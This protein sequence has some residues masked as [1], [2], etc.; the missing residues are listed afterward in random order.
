MFDACPRQPD[1]PDFE[2][3]Q[4]APPPAPCPC[5]G[6]HPVASPVPGEHLRG[7]GHAFFTP[8]LP[9]HRL[10][11]GLLLPE[12][13]G[14]VPRMYFDEKRFRYFLALVLLLTVVI[15]TLRF[16]NANLF[17]EVFRDGPLR[18]RETVPAQRL[19]PPVGWRTGGRSPTSASLPDPG[20]DQPPGHPPAAHRVLPGS[21]CPGPLAKQR[22]GEKGDG[23][24][25]A[26]C[27]AGAPEK[28]GEPPFL[29]QHP[30]QHL[31]PHPSDTERAGET[32]HKLSK[33]MRYLLY[34][35][36]HNLKDLSDEVQFMRNY[37]ELM[38]LRLNEKV[39]LSIDLPENPPPPPHILPLLFIP[40][41]ENAF[42]HGVSY[43]DESSSKSGFRAE[44]RKLS[45]RTRNSLNGHANSETETHSGIDG[46]R[47]EVVPVVSRE[48]R[49]PD[50]PGPG[51]VHGGDHRRHTDLKP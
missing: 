2:I 9:E 36:E 42:K 34:D 16:L 30:E 26:Q 7:R 25:D 39:R 48:A 27:R 45:F 38:Q 18:G 14:V 15:F 17:R 44:G 51:R 11:R 19:R 12:L 33:L 13:P 6:H 5:M 22:E 32:V 35:T 41:I 50:R 10:L 1:D 21:G 49:T 40:V 47:E 46:E 4:T 20:H 28:P 37:I 3:R 24:G 8:L 23:K 29:F 43:R 31:L